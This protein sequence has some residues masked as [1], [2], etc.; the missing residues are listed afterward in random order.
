MDLADIYKPIEDDLKEISKRLTKLLYTNDEYVIPLSCHI[1]KDNGKL[2]RPAMLLLSAKAVG[3]GN[4]TPTNK[5]SNYPIL[6]SAGSAIELIHTASLVHDDILDEAQIRRYQESVNKK[7]G[8]KTAVLFG[9]YLYTMAFSILVDYKEI[10]KILTSVTSSMCMGEVIQNLRKNDFNMT[11]E[12]Y[13]EI[14]TKKSALLF[15]AACRIGAILADADPLHEEAL[16]NYGINLGIAYQILDD[17]IDLIGKEE[18]TGKSLGSDVS[19][20]KITLP[21]IYLNEISSNLFEFSPINMEKIKKKI[22]KKVCDYLETAKRSLEVLSPSIYIQNIE[23]L[24]VQ[25][26]LNVLQVSNNIA[27]EELAEY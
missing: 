6:V 20:G 7:W 23:K 8:N 10:V 21:L 4:G 1:L 3:F 14:I 19:Q 22:N 24:L 16:Y 25:F 11:E 17:L 15:G 2:L 5:S 13:L 18:E 26:K 27:E 12:E 9:D